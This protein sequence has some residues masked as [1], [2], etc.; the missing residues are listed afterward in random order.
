MFKTFIPPQTGGMIRSSFNIG[1][2][3]S[4]V[5]FKWRK[6]NKNNN[7]KTNKKT[8]QTS[9]MSK[10]SH[11]VRQTNTINTASQVHIQKSPPWACDKGCAEACAERFSALKYHMPI[12]R[13]HLSTH[14]GDVIYFEAVRWQVNCFTRCSISYFL[15][16][17][18]AQ[19][20][21]QLHTYWTSMLWSIDSCQN[22]VSA[23][24]YHLTVSWAQVSTHRGQVF[25]EVIRW[26]VTSFQMI[27][28]SSL[29]FLKNSYEIC[30]VFLPHN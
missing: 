23:D 24:Q 12:S 10:R 1:C 28:G 8:L 9:T 22:R 30:R 5:I 25:F 26:Q 7:K 19:E 15:A 13:A 3:E 6:N 4:K 21:W 20:N 29:I 17:L 16:S 27:A 11:L 2:S 14:W 18:G